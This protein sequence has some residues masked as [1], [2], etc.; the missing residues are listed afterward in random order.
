MKYPGK[1]YRVQAELAGKVYGDPFGVDVSFGEPMLGPPDRV[2]GRAD[3]SFIGVDPAEFALYPRATH[4]AEKLHAFTMP[5]P[6]PNSRVRDLP[7]IAILASVGP[8][9]SAEVRAALEQTYAHRGTHAL[10][11]LLA[12]APERW[13]GPYAEMAEANRLP[14]ADLGTMHRAVG[15]FLGPALRGEQAVWEPKSWSWSRRETQHDNDLS[16]SPCTFAVPPWS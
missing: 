8:I 13:V 7:D 5:R 1:R 4:I 12:A 11:A 2:R 10:P 3:L 14:W 15:E 16:T 6:T 9:D